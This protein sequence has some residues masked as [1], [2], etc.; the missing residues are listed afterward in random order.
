M[1]SPP[2]S[3]TSRAAMMVVLLLACRGSSATAEL[4]LM[5]CARIP[6]YKGPSS[7]NANK[8]FCRV[9]L[10]AHQNGLSNSTLFVDV[11]TERGDEV[12][13]AKF[14]GHPVLT[15]EC[16]GDVALGHHQDRSSR[17]LLDGDVRLVH[18]CVSDRS[19]VARLHRALDSS[20]LLNASVASVGFK[21]GR[22]PFAMETVPMLTLDGACDRDSLTT[23]GWP[24]DLRIGLVK[25]DVQGAEPAVLR[26]A[27]RILARDDRPYL[28]YE[29]SMLPQPVQKGKL[30]EDLVG[31]GGRYRCSC[32]GDCFCQPVRHQRT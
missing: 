7:Q 16:R 6:P 13:I 3:P 30:L 4:S 1:Q 2:S 11:G 29:D 18:A 14:Y 15:F 10:T 19:G 9:L 24:S 31:G 22:E 26:G 17:R 28:L 20:S 12:R 8:E 25:I 5:R 21:V 23:L 27:Q 32:S